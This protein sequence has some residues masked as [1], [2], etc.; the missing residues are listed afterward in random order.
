[1]S[2]KLLVM[3]DASAFSNSSCLLKLFRV[4]FE[5]YTSKLQNN[6]VEFG[7]A[8]HIFRK[9]FREKG[10]EGIAEGLKLAKD[11][12]IK[13]PMV[14]KSNKKYL[15]PI[16]LMRICMEYA[17]KYAKDSFKPIRIKVKKKFSILTEEEKLKISLEYREQI[18][19]DDQIF[20]FEESLLEI[21]GAFPY[22]ID[23][24]IEILM[25]FTIDEIGKHSNGINCIVDAKTTSVWNTKEYFESFELSPQ[26]R[27][28][29]WSLLKYA[30]AYP[31]KFVAK[32]CEN[33]LGCFIDG[34]FYKGEN[35]DVEYKRSDIMLFQDDPGMVEFEQLI[36]NKVSSL[37]D[38]I[39]WYKSHNQTPLRE[40]ILNGA[41]QTKYGACNF[42]KVCSAIDETTRNVILDYNFIKKQYNPLEFH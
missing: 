9:V 30:E 13:T 7:T 22:Y 40:G 35:Q 21:K 12:Y 28:Y 1:M 3:L 19:Q 39:K 25:V 31:E 37:I 36:K 16:F 20:E 5:G 38:A 14:I 17:E 33:E 11:Y 6:D 10:E 23:D 2:E 41:C 26:L 8:F 34:I 24:E 15:T 27:F 4:S 32:L 18:I 29:K 42:S